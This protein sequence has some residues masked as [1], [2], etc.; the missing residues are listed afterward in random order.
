MLARNRGIAALSRKKIYQTAIF[1]Q[2]I[3]DIRLVFANCWLY[4]RAEAEEYQCGLR[5]EKYFLKEGKKQGLLTSDEKSNAP[6]AGGN[7]KAAAA[8]DDDDDGADEAS[9]RQPPAKRGRRTF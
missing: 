4:N 3:E 5:L 6:A 7:H 9:V 2:V 1:F 8:G